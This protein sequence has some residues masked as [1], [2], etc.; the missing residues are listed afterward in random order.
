M[1]DPQDRAVFA[2]IMLRLAE[3]MDVTLSDF[4]TDA[5]F[6]AM[7]DLDV[8]EAERLVKRWIRGGE[9]IGYGEI[10]RPTGRW[11]PKAAELRAL[12]F[13]HE[14]NPARPKRL[15]LPEP[16]PLE[17]SQGVRE[18]IRQL[19]AR[20][21]EPYSR[22]Q[23]RILGSDHLPPQRFKTI[24]EQKAALDEWATKRQQADAND[25]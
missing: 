16:A 15:S 21:S 6:E 24:E 3:A 20:F 9:V 1:R 10:E 5:Y 18:M 11:F 12:R 22:D 19:I 14:P 7:Q 2:G 8:S 25:I 17:M 23:H 13:V 4:R